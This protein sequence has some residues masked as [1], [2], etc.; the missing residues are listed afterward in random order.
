MAIKSYSRDPY[1]RLT[2]ITGITKF[3]KTSVFSGLNNLRDITLSR[4]YA[5][6]CGIPTE[7]LCRYFGEHIEYI[8]SLDE[9]CGYDSIHDEILS[10]YD[11]YSWDGKT[12]VINPFSLLGFLS[13]ER[14]SSFWYASGTP[15]FLLDLI[16]RRWNGYTGL[17]NPEMGEWELDTFDIKKMEAEPLLLQT[18]YLT[19][20]EILPDPAPAVYLLGIPN[21]EV[22][23]AF[24]LH[25]LAEFTESGGS[26]ATTAYRRIKESLKTGD[27]QAML[28]TLRS[29]FAS[30]PYQIHMSHEFYYHSIFCAMMN[31]LGFDIDAEVSVS[32]GRIDATL[33]LDDKV[34]IMEFKYKGCDPEATPEG[35]RKLFDNVLEEGMKQIKDRGYAK[36]YIGSGKTIYLAAFAFLGRDNIEMRTE[37]YDEQKLL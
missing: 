34:Y 9:F 32:G 21:F 16:K 18:G 2:F 15:K 8:S 37:G 5:N 31:L 10:W 26:L 20:K 29:L 27:L 1:L 35:K 24:N 4:K 13:E 19:V 36:K 12:R 6:I 33:E 3:S 23:F 28:E 14:F 22:R 11:G 30:I 17:S 7:D 25:I